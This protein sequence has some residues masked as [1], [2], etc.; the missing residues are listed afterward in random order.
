LVASGTY[1]EAVR[2]EYKNVVL[3]SETGAESTIISGLFHPGDVTPIVRLTSVDSF[4]VIEGFTLSGNVDSA[5]AAGAVLVDSSSCPTIRDNIIKNNLSQLGGGIGV[6]HS[7]CV[8]I[9]GNVIRNNQALQHGGGV[10]AFLSDRTEV[11]GNLVAYNQASPGVSQAPGGGGV[12]IL[13]SGETLIEWNAFVGNAAEFG[14]AILFNVGAFSIVRE[15]TLVYNGG[16]VFPKSSR[17]AG[18]HFFGNA[19]T[20]TLERNIIASSQ[21]GSGVSVTP[22]GNESP[23]MICNVFWMNELGDYGG[24]AEPGASD[25]YADP[26][27]CFMD[28]DSFSVAANS[29]CLADNNQGCGSIG[30][31]G[32]GCGSQLAIDEARAPQYGLRVQRIGRWVVEFELDSRAWVGTL[33][34]EIF[35]VQGRLIDTLLF[36]N[37]P[38]VRWDASS[39]TGNLAAAVLFARVGNGAV[40]AA[41]TFT[42]GL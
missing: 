33:R 38:R 14:G 30:A 25:M 23:E 6:Y 8:R 5:G 12:M 16:G 22:A 21:D 42:I 17:A 20:K 37:E 39:R 31:F 29:I 9:V 26:L 36:D 1:D 35:D 41:K 18:V 11:H 27:F 28:P 40:L 10:Y 34:L 4:T 3:K 7:S 15:N 2:V 24:A 32:P 13:L 19:S